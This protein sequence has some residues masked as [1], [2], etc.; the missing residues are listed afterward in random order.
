MKCS[1]CTYEH[2]PDNLSLLKS[3]AEADILEGTT[4]GIIPVVVWRDGEFFLVEKAEDKEPAFGIGITDPS[5]V[6]EVDLGFEPVP[7]EEEPEKF[8]EVLMKAKKKKPSNLL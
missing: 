7:D 6:E 3:H 5:S 2:K 4:R 1:F 8:Q